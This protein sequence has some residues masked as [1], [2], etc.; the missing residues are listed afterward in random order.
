MAAAVKRFKAVLANHGRQPPAGRGG[1][2]WPSRSAQ[3]RGWRV[4]DVIV[5]FMFDRAK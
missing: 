2:R 5:M 3:L 4:C 1:G